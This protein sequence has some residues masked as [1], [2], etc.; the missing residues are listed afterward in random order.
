MTRPLAHIVLW[1][2]AVGLCTLPAPAAPPAPA[3]EPQRAQ[4]LS[5]RGRLA[6]TEPGLVRQATMAVRRLDALSRTTQEPVEAAWFVS[7]GYT[8]TAPAPLVIYL[9]RDG[10]DHLDAARRLAR[11]HWPVPVAVLAVQGVTPSAPAPPSPPAPLNAPDP[12]APADSPRTFPNSGGAAQALR[13]VILEALRAFPTSRLILA[14]EGNGADAAIGLTFSFPRVIDGVVAVAPAGPSLA[15]LN[16]DTWPDRLTA[17][18]VCAEDD[19]AAP[20]LL[21]W[22][23]QEE[24]AEQDKT[25]FAALRVPGTPAEIGPDAVAL[26]V[27]AAVGLTALDPSEAIAAAEALALRLSPAPPAP[28]TSTPVAS[29]AMA[30][31]WSLARRIARRFEPPEPSAATTKPG[32]GP[33][34]PQPR[35]GQLSTART[36]TSPLR[37]FI[38]PDEDL[39]RRAF[40]LAVA[41]ESRAQAHAAALARPSDP[42]L[43]PVT[44]AAALSL[45]TPATAVPAAHLAWFAESYRGC[46]ACQG[47][48]NAIDYK[49]ALV[50]QSIH[51]RA[52]TDAWAS[53][54]DPA[55]KARALSAAVGALSIVRLSP[56]LLTR[57]QAWIASP[58]TRTLVGPSIKNLSAL[59]VHAEA[60]EAGWASFQAVER[61]AP[62]GPAAPTGPRRP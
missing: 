1:S 6:G 2:L 29:P 32:P 46:D 26:A 33:G 50:T 10:Q 31:P 9:H 34:Q 36:D 25:Q 19:T 52:L 20:A 57:A 37:R 51:A 13:D 4:L 44:A 28:A 15:E 5:L 18:F 24:L 55:A 48:L 54:Q 41:I 8:G 56:S 38:S 3:A 22:L 42:A 7:P 17:V 35:P 45:R 21:A 47:F 30:P 14:G 61:A 58:V 53:S 11:A 23:V 12:A 27:T 40:R 60:M 39:R 16:P 62:P 43:A 49:P 59:R